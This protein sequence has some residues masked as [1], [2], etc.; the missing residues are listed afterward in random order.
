MMLLQGRTDAKFQFMEFIQVCNAK[1]KQKVLST[2]C[3]LVFF[4]L[5]CSEKEA[6]K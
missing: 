6:L 4:H 5:R 3:R 2:V 1:E